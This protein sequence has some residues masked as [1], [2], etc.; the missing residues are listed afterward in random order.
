MPQII[1]MAINGCPARPP[2]PFP[3]LAGR[4]TTRQTTLDGTRPAFVRSPA[5]R[6]QQMDANEME[7]CGG[8]AKIQHSDVTRKEKPHSTESGKIWPAGTRR[9]F[10]QDICAGDGGGERMDSGKGVELMRGEMRRPVF[11][12]ESPCSFFRPDA[13]F[14]SMMLAMMHFHMP[15]LVFRMQAPQ[16]LMLF[17][18]FVD[19]SPICQW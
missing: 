3:T 10:S 8:R 18:L 19:A 15:F 13:I 2:T 5:R 12:Q 14:E 6:R 4:D 7:M 16:G 17:L 9:N 11:D 1:R